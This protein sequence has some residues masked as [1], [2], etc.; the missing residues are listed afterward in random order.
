MH[1]ATIAC[2]LIDALVR[3][4]DGGEIAGTVSKIHVRVGRMTA[5]APDNLRHLFGILAEGSAVEGADL[6]IEEIPVRGKC[7][8]CGVEFDIDG[9]FFSCR[10]C[11]SHDVDIISGR[12]L[13]I[14]AVEVD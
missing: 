9:A 2:H 13:M 4:I 3:R 11:G 7:K 6:E 5:V 8:A 12:E 14:A 1:E 10:G